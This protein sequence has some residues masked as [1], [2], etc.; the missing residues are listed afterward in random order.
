MSNSVKWPRT[1]NELRAACDEQIR[2]FEHSGGW[3]RSRSLCGLPE[4]RSSKRLHDLVAAGL[5]ERSLG[6]GTRQ[7]QYRWRITE[8][9]RRALDELEQ[10][11]PGVFRYS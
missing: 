11:D 7:A 4:D 9:G 8:A 1:L 6:E 10:S 3:V 2:Y 5:V